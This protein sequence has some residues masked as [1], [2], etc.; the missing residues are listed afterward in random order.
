MKGDTCGSVI[1]IRPF[2]K[3]GKVLIDVETDELNL[4]FNKEK[5]MFNVYEWTPYINDLDTSYQL[6]EK[7][8]KVDKR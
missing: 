7:D 1:L 3:I 8:R 5:V 6:E 2:L 4:K